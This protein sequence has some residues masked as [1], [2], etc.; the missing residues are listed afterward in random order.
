MSEDIK[1]PVN[2]SVVKQDV[3][4]P[5]GTPVVKPGQV[6]V[7]KVTPPPPS[8]PPQTGPR[9]SL[10]AAVV[11]QQQP[12]VVGQKPPALRTG[13][14]N[15]LIENSFFRC[16]LYSETSA[17]KT[18]TAARFAGP[19]YSR[20]ILTRSEDQLLPLVGEGF[21]YVYAPDAASLSYALKNPEALWPEWASL[22]DTE[23]EKTLIVDDLTK[24]VSILVESNSTSKDKRQAYTGALSDLDS[25]V[26]PLTRKPYN[27]ILITLAK[28]RENQ[29][30]GEEMIGPDLSPS[31]MNYVTA[32]FA[33]V[34]YIQTKN[35]K[36]LT[37]RDRFTVMGTDP[38]TG[39]E[40][41]FSREI[42]AK[43]KLPWS[44]LGKGVLKKEEVLDLRDVWNRI[45]G[46][47]KE[48]GKK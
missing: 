6:A 37:D 8:P 33:G 41:P 26:M 16:V 27:L 3:V 10:H 11:A 18:S 2:G 28:V 15:R 43:S 29:L 20:I 21:E 48:G 24:A 19:K 38:A 45:K 31:I 42:F 35:Y 39:K 47:Y 36:M 7:G 30:S 14:T 40:K 22:P 17:R 1:A 25:L 12:R 5:S 4:V 44:A 23:R 13:G 46:A 32:E 34:F 9:T